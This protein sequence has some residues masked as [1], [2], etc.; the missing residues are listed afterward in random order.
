[1]L[2]SIVIVY[3]LIT[4]NE[5]I[6]LIEM[7]EDMSDDF[8]S[9]KEIISLCGSFLII[10]EDTIYFMHQSAKDFLFKEAFNEIFLSRKG[11]AHY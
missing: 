9:V 8:K 7:P 6:S 11:K 3:R 5:L 1:M 10:R 2:T 4:L